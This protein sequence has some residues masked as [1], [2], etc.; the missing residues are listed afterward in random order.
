MH[1]VIVRLDHH[2]YWENQLEE[3]MGKPKKSCG[4]TREEMVKIRHLTVK[5][6]ENVEMQR[7]DSLSM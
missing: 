6:D 2:H 5:K 1:G 7:G 4:K 3:I